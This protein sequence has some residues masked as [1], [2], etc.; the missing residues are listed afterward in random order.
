[1]YV[2]MKKNVGAPPFSNNYL[3]KKLG[4]VATTRNLATVQKTLTL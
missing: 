3:E 2:L 1:V 4:L